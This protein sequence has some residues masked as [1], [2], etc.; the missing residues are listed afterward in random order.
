M[1]RT[2]VLL[3]VS[4]AFPFAASAG[5]KEDAEAVFASFLTAFT[6]AD[7]DGVLG[8]FAPEALVWGTGMRDLATTP[9]PVRQYFSAN[10]P[11]EPNQF[12]ASAFYHV[13]GG[14]L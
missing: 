8:L 3:A 12:S 14:A 1:T 13:V 6:A 7:L 10:G 4:L 5:P 2:L 11:S 9:E